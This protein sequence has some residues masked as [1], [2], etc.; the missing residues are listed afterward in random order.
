ME[1]GEKELLAKAIYDIAILKKQIHEL[2][3]KVL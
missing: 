1:E 2:K 3:Q